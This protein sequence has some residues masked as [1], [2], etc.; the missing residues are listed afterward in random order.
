[1]LFRS[2]GVRLEKPL[3]GWDVGTFEFT[4]PSI[5][6]TGV[7]LSAFS[8]MRLKLRTGGSTGKVER[9]KATVTDKVVEWPCNNLRLPVRH[10]YMSPVIIEFHSRGV[11]NKA[12]A[13]AIFWLSTIIDNET[14][15]FKLPIYKTDNFQRLTQNFVEE[16]EKERDVQVERIGCLE[17]KGRF[18]TGLDEDHGKF[19]S[20]NDHRETLETYEACVTK[21]L[22]DGIVKRK[23]G[24]AVEM[25]ATDA[26]GEA[27][28]VDSDSDVEDPTTWTNQSTGTDTTGANKK[29]GSNPGID[30]DATDGDGEA[31]RELNTTD[32]ED[33]TKAFGEDPFLLLREKDR[34][35]SGG[36]QARQD[37]NDEYDDY[38]TSDE[39]SG[40]MGKVRDY[41]RDKKDMHRKHHGAMQW[42]PVRTMKA[43][44]DQVKVGVAKA[45]TRL[46]MTGREP[47]VEAQ[48]LLM[49][50]D[51]SR[52]RYK[53]QLG[54][55]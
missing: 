53:H 35:K 46:S 6:A 41:K 28:D 34:R 55:L 5:V 9:S 31:T 43:M 2:V 30:S 3:L 25:L 13:H 18:K 47:D 54:V 27:P 23:V 36:I 20:D 22:R 48:R 44:K 21:G 45:K 37:T 33:W 32:N 49:I 14:L 1:M 24:P 4:S 26:Y 10:R 16:P 11:R 40:I 15:D 17:F 42:K 8:S 51:P 52:L 50:A 12:D 38:N 39:S 7:D 29:G 19:L